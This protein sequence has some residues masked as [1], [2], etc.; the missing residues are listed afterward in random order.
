MSN[1]FSLS[2]DE[3]LPSLSI[4][5]G[6]LTSLLD[7]NEKFLAAADTSFEK[8]DLY[9]AGYVGDK[10]N[11]YSSAG[12]L[13]LNTGNGPMFMGHKP[14]PANLPLVGQ[15][16][17]KAPTFSN[18]LH[19]GTE[20]T[21]F[22]TDS[23]GSL[24]IYGGRLS[25]AIL[26]YSGDF[27]SSDTSIPKD[28]IINLPIHQGEVQAAWKVNNEQSIGDSTWPVYV[29]ANGELLAISNELGS[30]KQPFETVV[31]RKFYLANANPATYA[32]TAPQGGSFYSPTTPTVDKTIL[33]IGN[34][35]GRAHPAAG[36]RYGE[37][38]IYPEATTVPIAIQAH[39]NTYKDTVYYF[40]GG[41]GQDKKCYGVWMPSFLEQD[42]DDYGKPLV[43]DNKKPVMVEVFKSIGSSNHPVY[44]D[45]N[46]K[47][48]PCSGDLGSVD[49]PWTAIHAQSFVLN[50][51]NKETCGELFFSDKC[52][53]FAIGNDASGYE[54]Q[55][56]LY[57]A[58]YGNQTIIK[59]SP[60]GNEMTTFY[61]PSYPSLIEAV[62]HPLG[63][64]CG[65]ATTPIYITSD[66][67]VTAGT[68]YAG[69]TAITLNVTDCSGKSA[70]FY[71]PLTSGQAT[72]VLIGGNEDAPLWKDIDS[73]SVQQALNDGN[74]N[75]ITN[76][77][78]TKDDAAK[79]L[80][81]AKDYTDDQIQVSMEQHLGAAQ[82]LFEQKGAANTALTEAK[83][84]TDSEVA[85]LLG[86]DEIAETYDT[87]KEIAD[88]IT[89]SGVDTT[90]LASA[91]ADEAVAR[92]Q[93]LNAEAAA[94]DQAIETALSATVTGSNGISVAGTLKSLS[95]SGIMADTE[96]VGMVSTGVQS[97][98][99]DKSFEGNIYPTESYKYTLGS[100]TFIWNK[101][102]SAALA[103]YTET[104]DNTFKSTTI[105]NQ[106]PGAINFYLPN[107]TNGTNTYAVWS[108]QASTNVGSTAKPVYVD[109]TGKINECS[110][111]AGGT[112]VTLN[113]ASK[114]ATTA[115]FY[116]PTAAGTT[117]Y[118]LKS[119][120]SDATNKTP[121]WIQSVP[122]AN[123]GTGATALT[124][125]RLL[126]ATSSAVT[127]SSHYIDGDQLFVN[128][129]TVT[130]ALNNIKFYVN[131]AS[132]F[133]GKIIGASSNY[134]SSLPTS[135]LTVGQIYFKLL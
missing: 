9:I 70:K 75:L 27:D 120:G 96:N 129:P 4:K 110:T 23:A 97:F 45:S 92:E 11:S 29:S 51:I 5:T 69:G 61:L 7:K 15:G 64:S 98:K 56:V 105:F 107:A 19:L 47:L 6:L 50:N 31:A 43:D 48:T 113:G 33:E 72:Q 66:G 127:T 65:S 54:G 63:E 103:V 124:P 133:N 68:S 85:K 58:T 55:I 10:D 35:V 36:P 116:A 39:P 126:Y 111:Y 57:G 37:I 44:V 17:N 132:Q 135:N 16:A 42:V 49:N 115:S 53:T 24:S 87:L 38:K 79:K 84:Y 134:G 76:T 88:W 41:N 109:A 114:G 20:T 83:G 71:A 122:I 78:E 106:S 2:A 26:K 34:R 95:I 112:A 94:R 1:I 91:I 81:E 28:T 102:C 108:P 131:G 121:V 40:P 123:G 46:G 80:D 13:V 18:I 89:T 8:G 117:G 104:T 22:N 74:G 128:Q 73:L 125:N 60:T 93:G 90:D 12:T 86:G 59:S 119:C 130:T 118:I 14:G 25:R 62:W 82:E 3:K 52:T 77:Y 30:V 101:L 21:I 100:S 32:A 67:G 99:G